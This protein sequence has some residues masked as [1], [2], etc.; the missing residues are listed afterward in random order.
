MKKKLML[1]TLA[2]TLLVVPATVRADEKDDRIAELEA[3]VEEMQSVIDQLTLQ[4]EELT[5]GSSL[6]AYNLGDTWT[7]P[8]QWKITIDSVEETPDRNGYANTN[9]AAVYILTYTYENIG[10]ESDFLDGLYIDLAQGIVDAEG[11][12]GYDYPGSVT[13]YPQAAPVGASCKA[14]ICVG[15]EHAGSFQIH[16]SDYDGSGTKQTAVFNVDVN[17]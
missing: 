17:N 16:Y 4:L 7:V 6:D 5:T 11:T 1:F 15:V 9:P 2:A 8:G 12:M 3:Q 14:Q 10:Y 13:Y